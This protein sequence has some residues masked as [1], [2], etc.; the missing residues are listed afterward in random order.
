MEPLE[1]YFAEMEKFVR[2]PQLMK[3]L[4]L[5]LG[6]LVA[7]VGSGGLYAFEI[8]DGDL[9]TVFYAKTDVPVVWRYAPGQDVFILDVP[10]LEQLGLT[11]NRVTQFKEHQAGE[12]Y[13]RVLTS[14]ELARYIAASNKTVATFAAGHDLR[15]SDL[16]QFFNFAQRDKV[17]LFPQ[18]YALRDFMIEQGLMM[19]WREMYRAQKPHAVILSIPQVQDRR[20]SEPAVTSNMRYAILLHELAHAAF[21][22]N[23]FYKKYCTAFWTDGLAE[24][25]KETFRRFLASMR[26]SIDDEDLVINEMQAY[27]M[28]TPDTGSFSAARLGVSKKELAIMRDSFAKGRPPVQLPLR[29]K[30]GDL[31]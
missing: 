4:V 5:F 11:F 21:H 13:P 24:S 25:Q 27:L 17:E 22:T 1:Q 29:V 20:A 30:A 2:L 10:G 28:F 9:K 31:P 7:L 19:E 12:A 18:E 6:L 8:K 14:D 15:V 23:P 16:V 3:R 26:Y